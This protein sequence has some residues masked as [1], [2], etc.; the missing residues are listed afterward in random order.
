MRFPPPSVIATW[1]R[2][3]YTDPPT[4]GPELL[5]TEVTTLSLAL[6]CLALRLW[7]RVR[8]LHKAWWDDWVMVA[9]GVC[10]T[11]TTVDVILATK[12]YGWDRHIWD[13]P[14]WMLVQGRKVSAAGQAFFVFASG[15][16]KLSILISYLRIAL[17]GTLFR[18]LTWAAIVVNTLNML[19]FFILL[20][21]QCRWL[22]NGGSPVC[23]T[24][25]PPSSYWNLL[26]TES[27]CI[28][29]VP[30]LL[31]QTVL[32]VL[33][34]FWVF[35]L[36]MPTLYHLSLPLAQRVGLMAL[37]GLGAV[38]V[39]AG[40]MRTYWVHHVE[41]ETYDVTWEGYD[42]WIWAAVEANL[43]VICGCAPILRSL[44]SDGGER[45]LRTRANLGDSEEVW[46]GGT[47]AANHQHRYGGWSLFT[48]TGG[49]GGGKRK[50]GKGHGEGGG[51]TTQ[52][53]ASSG[54]VVGR[55]YFEMVRIEAGT[56]R[57]SEVPSGRMESTRHLYEPPD[58]T[59][60]ESLHLPRQ[61]A[62]NQIK[63]PESPELDRRSGSWQ[64]IVLEE[65]AA[66]PG[67][68]QVGRR[69]SEAWPLGPLPFERRKA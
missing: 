28:S 25:S 16:G 17:E 57:N 37:F 35:V 5:I 19:A 29:E 31:T 7:V 4:R 32:T 62:E 49:G 2:P 36:P 33:I 59:S 46:S 55:P 53:S 21:V 27:D 67:S 56:A 41:L 30:G 12:L 50:R 9:A 38:V 60:Q 40:C 34:D 8:Q 22:M 48:K 13:V 51:S 10:C 64:Y 68:P 45:Y 66:S 39:A 52:G 1:P 15:L 24:H 43:G 6:I 47:A 14:F 54:M 65:Q 61:V 26:R 20:W 69:D 63:G 18:R 58:Y 11:G 23:P 42:L 44:V 3:N